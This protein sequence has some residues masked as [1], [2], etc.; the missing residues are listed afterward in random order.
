MGIE[1]F[2]K[3][4]EIILFLYFGSECFWVFLVRVKRQD[5]T[6]PPLRRL[7]QHS[8]PLRRLHIQRLY[9]ITG[10]DPDIIGG[11]F[12]TDSPSALYCNTCGDC[13][14]RND[15]GYVGIDENGC[16]TS[17]CIW[18]P[19]DVQGEP[20][21]IRQFNDGGTGSDGTD[22]T[23]QTDPVDITIGNDPVSCVV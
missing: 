21:C 17:G 6:L 8:Q 5:L 23:P 11:W 10:L 12:P 22:E 1:H 18:C 7:L 3:K 14:Q 9:L 20:W 15:C 2:W 13:N 19:S 4:N 16:Q